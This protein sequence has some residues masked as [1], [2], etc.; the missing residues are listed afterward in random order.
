MMAALAVASIVIT[1][2]P[3][4]PQRSLWYWVFYTVFVVEFV[5]RWIRSR[6]LGGFL[7]QHL[8][9]TIVLVP[10]DFMQSARLLRLTRLLRLVRGT[11][12]LWRTSRTV[13]GILATNGLGT[14]LLTALLITAGGGFWISHVEPEMADLPDAL[15]WSVVTVTTVGY[16]DLSPQTTLGRVIAALLMF[17]GIGTIGMMTGSIATYFL[18]RG[19]T[20]NPEVRHVQH[21]LTD[22]DTLTPIERR[23]LAD[24]LTALAREDAP[25]EP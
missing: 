10:L 15:W 2:R 22:W 16:G 13:R 7:R 17:T 14:V 9:E 20:R 3:P 24:Q 11:E 23:R 8:L 6:S 21:R 18:G 25:P 12:V 19:G 4:S 5:T 1:L